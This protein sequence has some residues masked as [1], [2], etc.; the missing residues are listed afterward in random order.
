MRR[1]SLLAGAVAVLGVAAPLRAATRYEGPLFDAH[2]HY[3]DEAQQPHPLADVQQQYEAN[4][5]R[6][7]DTGVFGAP[8]YVIDGEI[9][10]G[11]DRLEF[12]EQA[13]RP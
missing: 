8:S 11:Q 13:L 1:R 3:N 9:F 10:W 6:A 2:L 12:V 5:Q 4:T 7:I